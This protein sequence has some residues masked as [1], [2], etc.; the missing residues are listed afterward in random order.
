M[1]N[2]NKPNPDTA[3]R[4]R[5]AVLAS[6][7]L[8]AGVLATTASVT[9]A[10]PASAA[11]PS[12][13]DFGVTAG[14]QTW[15]VPSGVHSV[16]L[17]VLGGA[18]GDGA[19]SDPTCAPRSSGAA[20]WTVGTVGVTPGQTL[21]VWVGSGGHVSGAGGVA[22]PDGAFGGG[23]G[24]AAGSGF[25]YNA[26][27]GTGG[28]GGAASV[29]WS[30]SVNDAN[31]VAVGGGGGGGGGE[32]ATIYSCG[33]DGG[34]GGNPAGWGAN[35][36]NDH[37]AGGSYAFS[38]SHLGE[39]GATVPDTLPN[40]PGMG[41]GGGG[42]GG[43]F[44][45]CGPDGLCA[46]GGGGGADPY[47]NG[48]GGGGGGGGA[49]YTS[50]AVT[51]TFF[52]SAGA[53]GSA[54]SVRLTWG[55]PSSVSISSGVANVGDAVVLRALV[56]PAD[57]GGSV[58][59][60]SDGITI[61][62]CDYVSFTSGG[63]TTWL[64]SCTTSSLGAGVHE[65]AATYS[66]DTA[67]AG[68]ANSAFWTVRQPTTTTVSTTPASPATAG[69]SLTLDALIGHADGGG[70]TAFTDNGVTVSG[71]SAVP[72]SRSMTDGQYHAV[73]ST[74]APAA[75]SHSIAATF[76]GD[77]IDYGSS[78]AAALSV[79]RAATAPGAPTLGSVTA[80]N[81]S[82]TVAFTAP[83]SVGSSPITVYSA[84]ATP[85]GGGTAKTET[86]IGSPLTVTG[87]TNG[88]A[89]T[90]NVAATNAVGTGPMSTPSA[91]ITPGVQD[92]KLTLKRSGTF[93][94][95]RLGTYNALVTNTG[96]AAT[97]GKLTL[98]VTMPTGLAL[99]A[100]S[101]SG[102]TC[103]RSG[104][105][106]T[107]TRT[108]ALAQTASTQV[109]MTVLVNAPAGTTLT[110]KGSISPTDSTPADNTATDTFRVASA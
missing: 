8:A 17:S 99:N 35:S 105:V 94:N 36:A 4:G 16:A 80:G 62:G 55:A 90:V 9:L 73:C 49:S 67:Y 58:R 6:G 68:S 70:T 45:Y 52:S 37:S 23:A 53:S 83:S 89:Y 12:E 51:D 81:G 86:G 24:G 56:D 39:A 15:T 32:G 61:P 103:T 66:G 33:G 50:S 106:A 102:W 18:G 2:D 3:R 84:T 74:T 27:S 76:S 93:A 30:G 44:G 28:G 57:G 108:A 41:G 75:G 95:R 98:Q 71:C 22:T 25:G 77:S 69:A 87:L 63:D 104:Q 29:V 72:T 92:L 82:V 59:F 101:G 38:G 31:I 91:A 46:V 47:G 97:R 65:V 109:A 96:T 19:L 14:Y 13:A 100:A 7:L 21:T 42:G 78:G 60:T 110:T 43:G 79:V 1:T 40:T 5:L 85:V 34:S 10:S 20:G 54:G 48:A 26:K 11:T 107:C 64:A 88:T